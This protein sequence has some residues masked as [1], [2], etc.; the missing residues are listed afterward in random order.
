MLCPGPDQ[1]LP[2]CKVMAVAQIPPFL[3]GCS[4]SYCKNVAHFY[5][6]AV[7]VSRGLGPMTR[8]GLPP[9]QTC[10]K[11]GQSP[12]SFLCPHTP[13]GLCCGG[14]LHSGAGPEDDLQVLFHFIF[15]RKPPLSS[16]PGSKGSW[17]QGHGP[18]PLVRCAC[19]GNERCTA[20]PEGSWRNLSSF[21]P[22]FSP[23]SVLMPQELNTP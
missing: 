8:T 5:T 11:R 6:E 3:T 2:C 17:Q 12:L 15:G 18:L 22:V 14:E 1:I 9:A 23:L 20:K 10:C 16:I 19:L 4:F 7:G 21:F 13:L